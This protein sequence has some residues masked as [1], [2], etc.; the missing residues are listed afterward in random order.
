[1]AD[2]TADTG[3]KAW[4][5]LLLQQHQAFTATRSL[6]RPTVEYKGDEYVDDKVIVLFLSQN[7]FC[8]TKFQLISCD[9]PGI[10]LRKPVN[11]R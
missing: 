6:V 11:D 7:N 8:V 1:M 2:N 5:L 3:S 9:I 10:K 4:M